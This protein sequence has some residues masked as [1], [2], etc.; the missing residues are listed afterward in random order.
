MRTQWAV[1][2]AGTVALGVWVSPMWAPMVADPSP[3]S[4]FALFGRDDLRAGR[5]FAFYEAAARK[6]QHRPY[7]CTRLWA[8]AHVCRVRS[9][10]IPGEITLVVDSTDHAILIGFVPSA[11]LRRGER[12]ALAPRDPRLSA[13]ILAERT[14]VMKT[15]WDSIG[16]SVD[17]SLSWADAERWDD[18]GAR[19]SARI[20]YA[21]QNV[22][23][24]EARDVPL[25][26]ELPNG[27]SIADTPAMRALVRARPR[28]DDDT[29]PSML[30]ALAYRVT[31]DAQRSTLPSHLLSPAEQMRRVEMDLRTLL[32]AQNVFHGNTH[33]Y[34]GSLTTLKFVASPGVQVHF[35]TV[36][37]H[38]W[39]AT[40][41]MLGLGNRNCVVW[42]GAVGRRPHTARGR[43]T[44][45][46]GEI[47]CDVP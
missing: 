35:V 28:F 30:E 43:H 14:A 5:R 45:R 6:A 27:I 37:D 21:H 9:I 20:W 16:V 18:P 42:E 3:V 26:A 19:W 31:G 29:V 33:G 34:T 7:R 44:E 13:A 32:A 40:A 2:T 36:T 1:L 10:D 12:D 23:P 22:A 46:S 38:G 24:R 8:R 25:V 47:V 4:S 15:S 41:T 39:I 11:A 17:T